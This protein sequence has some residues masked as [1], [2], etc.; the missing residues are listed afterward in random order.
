MQ[1][2]LE[3]IIC[4]LKR[5]A[6]LG[7]WLGRRQTPYFERCKTIDRNL[8]LCCIYSRDVGAH[9]SGWK[10][11]PD[12]ERCFHLSVSFFDPLTEEAMPR[13]APLTRRLLVGIF[14]RARRWLWCEPPSSP[15]GKRRHVWHYRLFC[16]AAWEAI[17][18]R[19]EPYNR[20]FTEAGWLSYSDLQACL[21]AQRE[22][23][24]LLPKCPHKN[25]PLICLA[26]GA[27]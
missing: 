23:G 14:G 19:G 12:Y 20:Q 17:K 7:I 2:T 16:N 25:D 13:N 15:D 24:V 21:W 9:T 4:H 26:G 6:A 18:P 27:R 1:D 22:R 10:K 8:G 11:N 5:Q 3:G